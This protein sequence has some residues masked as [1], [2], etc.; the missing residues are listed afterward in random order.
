MIWIRV[1][2]E[3]PSCSYLLHCISL[4]PQN[5][6]RF[7]HIHVHMGVHL[8]RQ[9]SIFTSYALQ[10]RDHGVQHFLHRKGRVVQHKTLLHHVAR[11]FQFFASYHTIRIISVT[12][13]SRSIVTFTAALVFFAIFAVV[14]YHRSTPLT[15]YA[16]SNC[17]AR[18][19]R[20][21]LDSFRLF[22]GG[23][24]PVKPFTKLILLTRQACVHLSVEPLRQHHKLVCHRRL[25]VVHNV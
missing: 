20:D 7:Q 6:A 15:A 23:H 14:I 4:Q 19:E 1:L 21:K 13:I 16:T 3:Y 25:Y 9:Q 18:R 12:S 10:K 22:F 11:F 8:R 5:P 24:H 2:L 17:F